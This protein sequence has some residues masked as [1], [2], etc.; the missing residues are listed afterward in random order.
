MLALI[1]EL[2]DMPEWHR[3]IFD[4]EF[5]FRWKS[6]KVMT[7][8]DIRRSMADWVTGTGS[9]FSCGVWLT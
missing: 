6:G 3:K 9:P 4:N 7:G 1:N 8:V 2:T 5:T